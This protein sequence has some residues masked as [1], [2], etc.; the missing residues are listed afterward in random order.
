MTL[1]VGSGTTYRG[2]VS[3]DLGRRHFGVRRIRATYPIGRLRI[4]D[5]EAQLWAS[6]VT[7]P[8]SLPL[9]LALTPETA[10]VVT[11]HGWPPG[12]TFK[13]SVTTHHFW[14]LHPGRM[15]EEL[16]TAGFRVCS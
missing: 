3:I 16:Q 9:P 11:R 15:M 7:L 1:S 5:G 2:G 6:T 12:V 14:T 13:T 8:R 10:C 4:A